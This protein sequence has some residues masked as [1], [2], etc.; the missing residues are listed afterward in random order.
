MWNFYPIQAMLANA[1]GDDI[2]GTQ[3]FTRIYIVGEP[4]PEP[5]VV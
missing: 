2:Y 4:A 3:E 5:I 1:I